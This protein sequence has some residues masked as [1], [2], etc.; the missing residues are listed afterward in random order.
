MNADKSWYIREL[1]RELRIPYGMLYK[2][3]K[4]LVSLGVINEEKR[5]KVTNISKYQKYI[6]YNLFT[7][8]RPFQYDHGKIT[9]SVSSASSL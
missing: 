2:E 8:V 7:E 9:P 4:N 5:G 1:S 6:K 3:V